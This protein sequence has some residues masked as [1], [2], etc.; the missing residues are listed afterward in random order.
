MHPTVS[1][2]LEEMGPEYYPLC[3]AS[4]SSAA[5]TPSNIWRFS[6]LGRSISVICV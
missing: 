3:V 2:W 5:A 6:V 4:F 1:N